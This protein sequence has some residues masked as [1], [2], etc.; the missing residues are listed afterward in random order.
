MFSMWINLLKKKCQP[1]FF[2][3]LSPNGNKRLLLIESILSGDSN[4]NGMQKESETKFTEATSSEISPKIPSPA[5]SFQ[6]QYTRD[7]DVIEGSF[8]RL[9]SSANEIQVR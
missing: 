7:N 2:Q 1:N 9:T 3:D 6:E 4:F 8:K 5:G